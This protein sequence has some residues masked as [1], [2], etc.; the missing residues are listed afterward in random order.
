MTSFF[1]NPSENRLKAGWRILIFLIIFWLS[2]SIVFFVRPLVESASKKAFLQDYSLLIVAI[3]A[4]GATLATSIARKYVD[5][6]SFSSLGLILNKQT[7]KDLGFGFLLSA[8]MAGLF[9]SLLLIFNLIEFNGFNIT[10]GTGSEVRIANFVDYMKVMSIGTLALLLLEDIFVGYWEELF[11]RGYLFQNMVEGLGNTWTILISCILYGLVHAANPNASILSSLIIVLFG[12]LRIYGYLST[13]MLWLSIG[14]HIGWNFF[15]GP[16][17][18][19]A[20]SGHQKATLIDI[21]IISDKAWLSGGEFGPEG[22]ILIIP[23]IL[24]VLVIMKLYTRKR[25]TKN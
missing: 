6:K 21:N 17:F 20:A 12:F 19:F 11:F 23:I 2:A 24:I 7:L 13:K 3:L 18:G 22:S 10:N 15:Q 1:L 5:K 4:F 8:G 14:M 25:N 16:I 9:Y